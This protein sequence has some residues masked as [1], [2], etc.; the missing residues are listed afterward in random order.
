MSPSHFP[1]LNSNEGQKEGWFFTHKHRLGR[2]ILCFKV[3]IPIK[4]HL[5]GLD[6]PLKGREQLCYPKGGT[7]RCRRVG[8]FPEAG[9]AWRGGGSALH[10]AAGGCGAGLRGSEPKSLQEGRKQRDPHA[11]LGPQGRC[12]HFPHHWMRL[13]W[14]QRGRCWGGGSEAAPGVR[15]G[16]RRG[17]AWEREGR[18]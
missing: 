2:E 14:L 3:R 6:E 1:T 15:G 17:G 9:G 8:S 5:L 7:Q 10:R 16:A 13:T 18:K 11:H 4:P 12:R